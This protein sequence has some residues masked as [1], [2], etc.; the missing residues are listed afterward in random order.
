MPTWPLEPGQRGALS[1]NN[2]VVAIYT[3]HG[4]FVGRP[5]PSFS[6][7]AAAKQGF[8]YTRS[9]SGYQGYQ[10]DQWD[11]TGENYYVPHSNWDDSPYLFER[12]NM[13]TGRLKPEFE[14]LFARRYKRVKAEAEEEVEE[15]IPVPR[16]SVSKPEPIKLLLSEMRDDHEVFRF[17]HARIDEEI[18]HAFAATELHRPNPAVMAYVVQKLGISRVT[19]LE[20][21]R[22][23]VRKLMVRFHPDRFKPSGR[24]NATH[25]QKVVTFL[26]SLFT[27]LKNTKV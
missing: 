12:I 14:H 13:H 18:D 5:G 2:G 3:D 19:K 27:F 25:H 4:V 20:D 23:D 22:K 1:D 9:R 6:R 24:F 8:W 16:G 11:Y 17:L 21:V 15:E 7:A 26:S 10:R